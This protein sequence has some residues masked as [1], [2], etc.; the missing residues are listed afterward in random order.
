LDEDREVRGKASDAA[1]D[2][3][4]F[5]PSLVDEV[6]RA[7]SSVW[8]ASMKGLTIRSSGGSPNFDLVDILAAIGDDAATSLWTCRNVECSGGEAAA[9][10]HRASDCGDVLLGSALLEIARDVDQTI[11]G[12]FSGARYGEDEPWLRIRAVDGSAFDVESTRP[13]VLERVRARF[14]IVEDLP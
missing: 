6:S 7:R 1:D 4:I 5:I 11:D 12:E 8:T 10:L 13:S 2:I 9:A 14:E 3:E